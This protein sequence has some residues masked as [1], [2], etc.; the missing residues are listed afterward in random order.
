M[1]NSLFIGLILTLFACNSN[2]QI[3]AKKTV[4]PTI[5][6]KANKT[7]ELEIEGMVC[8]MGCGSS[9]RKELKNTHAVSQCSFDFKEDRKQNS[10]TIS[11]DS[12]QISSQKIIALIEKL[13]DRQFNVIN[14]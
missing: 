10:A 4:Q 14:Q 11:F 13:N 9:I 8:E 6:A 12:T 1:R 7:I 5:T 2:T 3:Q